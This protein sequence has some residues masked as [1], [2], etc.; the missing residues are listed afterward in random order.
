MPPTTLNRTDDFVQVGAAVDYHARGWF[1][2]GVGYSLMMNNVSSGD[3]VMGR[4]NYV[5]HQIFGRIGVTY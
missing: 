2:I 3:M 5:K 4:A 1:Y